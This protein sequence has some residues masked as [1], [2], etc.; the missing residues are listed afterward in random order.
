M[1]V[2]IERDVRKVHFICHFITMEVFSTLKVN[3][4]FQAAVVISIFNAGG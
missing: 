3:N 2:P 4:S 1:F